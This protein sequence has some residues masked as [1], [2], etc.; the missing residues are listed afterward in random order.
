MLTQPLTTENLISKLLEFPYTREKFGNVCAVNELPEKS[1]GKI[2]IVNTD[3]NWLPGMHW[4]ACY[5]SQTGPA[6]FFDSL[7]IP[8]DYYHEDIEAF[9]LRNSNQGY[10]YN[11]K[12]V[13]GYNS[14]CG[15]FCLYF[16]LNRAV[17]ISMNIIVHSLSDD[18]SLNDM[19]VQKF[20]KNQ[21]HIK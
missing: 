20:V 6:G 3:P 10:I 18:W 11:S 19:I 16:S 7:G 21:E 5:F 1:K 13:Q 8:P 14:T 12:R 4:V 17:G 2:Y 9:L 15:Y